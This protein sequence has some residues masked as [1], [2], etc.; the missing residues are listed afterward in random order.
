MSLS[1]T[2]VSSGLLSKDS[3]GQ[4]ENRKLRAIFPPLTTASNRHD[5]DAN[6]YQL[7]ANYAITF[8]FLPRARI[9][10]IWDQV[11][12]VS[13]FTLRNNGLYAEDFWRKKF[14]HHF[15]LKLFYSPVKPIVG[16]SRVRVRVV[17]AEVVRSL[18][19][20]EQTRNLGLIIFP[21]KNKQWWVSEK[22]NARKLKGALLLF[23]KNTIAAAKLMGLVKFSSDAN[24]RARSESKHAIRR[25]ND[26]LIR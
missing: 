2:L 24:S 25:G 4:R 22:R 21:R 20:L 18:R 9:S 3:S 8:I 5:V 23:I 15:S 26:R 19:V 16:V 6:C 13:L 14:H 17:A 11:F 12:S 1:C 7:I 10:I